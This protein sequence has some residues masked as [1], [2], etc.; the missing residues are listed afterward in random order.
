MH[1][2]ATLCLLDFLLTSSQHGQFFA[3][4]ATHRTHK[5][6]IFGGS[7]DVMESFQQVHC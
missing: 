4:A 5:P 6:G 2:K 1:L 7:S 3:Y